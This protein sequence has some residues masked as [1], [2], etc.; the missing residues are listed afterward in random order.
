MNASLCKY[1][2]EVM[3][4]LRFGPLSH[5][6]QAHVTGC[7]EC[8]EV[9][10]VANCLERDA[11]SMGEIS[12]PSADLVWRRAILRSRAE[13]AAR[14]I[15]PIQLVVEASIAVMITAAFWL[16]LGSPA[17][18]G[19]LPASTYTASLHTGRGMWVAVSLVAGLVTILTALFGAVYIL[20]ADC[21]PVAPVRPIRT[22][23]A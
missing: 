15:R 7:V 16:I 3:K 2:Q 6:L 14:A 10:L 5:E 22:R 18:L 4:A 17:W 19:A 12:I 1:E 11:H 8:S 13:A 20:R 21:V 23:E 9:V